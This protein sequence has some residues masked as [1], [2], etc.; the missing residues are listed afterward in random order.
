MNALQAELRGSVFEAGCSNWYINEH[1]RNA[2]SWPGYASSYWKEALKPQI[3]VFKESPQS[4][5]WM[6][7]TLWR[8][9][10]TTSKETYAV[11]GLILACLAW[12][13]DYELIKAIY[14]KFRMCL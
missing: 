3:G 1:G 9:I 13:W 5:L 10:R 12:D 6:L 11:L 8:W 4:R 14:R 7:N 2:A